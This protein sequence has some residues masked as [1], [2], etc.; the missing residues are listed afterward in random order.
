MRPEAMD[1]RLVSFFSLTST[2]MAWPLSS[3]C[4]S[5]FSYAIKDHPFSLRIC[6][7]EFYHKMQKSGYPLSADSL[8]FI[9]ISVYQHL[10]PE[11]FLA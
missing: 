6:C 4:V 2:M 11:P 3:K 10:M 8:T 1:V 9:A 5:P 7:L